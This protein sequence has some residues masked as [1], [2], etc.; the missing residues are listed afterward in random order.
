MLALAGLPTKPEQHQDGMNLLPLI[1]GEKS[2][3]REALFWHFPHYH[4]STWAPGAAIRM[5]EWKLIEFYD[6]EKTELYNLHNDVGEHTDL[7]DTH[8]E[9]V[10]ELKDKL[11][12]LQ[13]ETEAKFPTPNE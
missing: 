4:G 5:G 13:K 8:P 2:L 7:S 3:E 10:K 11:V 1:K 12:E 9:K 6:Y